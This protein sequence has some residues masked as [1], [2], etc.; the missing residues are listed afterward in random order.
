MLETIF[1][2]RLVLDLIKEMVFVLNEN[3][4]IVSVNKAAADKLK[5]EPDYLKIKQIKTVLKSYVW[6]SFF[7]SLESNGEAEL[8]DIKLTTP[9]K[10]EIDADLKAAKVET[11][12]NSVIILIINDISSYKKERLELLRFSNA[13]HF[14]ANPIQITD[15]KGTMVYVNPAMEKASGY[16]KEEL[17]G[18]NPNILSSNKL[19]KDFWEKVWRKILSG[20][21]WAGQLEN[22]K[23][24]GT[25]FY[26]DSIISPIFDNDGSTAGYL[27]VHNEISNNNVIRDHLQCIQ[28]LGSFGTLTAGI[29]HEVGNPL[30]SIS[31]LT[32]LIQKTTNDKIIIDKLEL[33]KNQV[34]R[35]S[36]ILRQ[37]VDFSRPVLN[38]IET[39][40]INKVLIKAVNMVK[41]GNDFNKI[42]YITNLDESIP[43][44]KFSADQLMQ[45]FINLL[46]NAVDAIGMNEGIIIII[47]KKF[48]EHLEISI[49]DSGSG[50]PPEKINKIFQPFYST[51]QEGKGIGLGL[52][53]SYGIIRNMGGDI[54][55][56]SKEN[57]GSEF[58]IVLPVNP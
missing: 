20:K 26:A 10:V 36:N 17:L 58:K 11:G 2:Y 39:V 15:A 40:E 42:Q 22:K 27:G 14:A 21:V 12:S 53:V 30:T 6:I 48:N 56:E 38:N 18:K 54:F 19:S 16:S 25:S 55:V 46:F 5:L 47:T 41:I 1:D 34:N 23:K 28:R 35:I 44:V 31:S 3:H 8:N 51:K 50:I 7:S 4:E 9:D 49:G 52:W 13:L 32:Q 45:V 24:N 43:E 29:A 37:L 57:F 33:V